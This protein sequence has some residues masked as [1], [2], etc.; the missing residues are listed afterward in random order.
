MSSEE[1][2]GVALEGIKW[3]DPVVFNFA[4][5]VIKVHEL[6]TSSLAGIPTV[7]FRRDAAA[8]NDYTGLHIWPAS[9]ILGRALVESRDL[10]VGKRVC[11]LG[12]GCG[13]P[14][15]ALA[16]CLQLEGKEC[17]IVVTDYQ[18][19]TY[20]VLQQNLGALPEAPDKATCRIEARQ[21]D[22]S[23]PGTYPAGPCDLVF[24]S[25]T[26]YR[27]A[28][29]PLFVRIIDALCVPADC[30]ERCSR[31]L[32]S[33]PEVRQGVREFVVAMG[34]AGF[35]LA[36]TRGCPPAWCDPALYGLSELEAVVLFPTMFS[37]SFRLWE[38]VRGTGP[39]CDGVAF[40][41]FVHAAS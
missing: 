22:W 27:E 24:A 14:S 10:C 9:I 17:D 3:D 41:D 21:V 35:R 32:F 33:A 11:E 40:L 5:S 2:E 16:A 19:T 4:G 28:Q 31:V 12:A 13:L 18:A 25:D 23:V 29:V 30:S 37:D 8:E 34:E 26:V 7:P 1:C 20:C 6:P 38:F 36:D 39:G 15:L